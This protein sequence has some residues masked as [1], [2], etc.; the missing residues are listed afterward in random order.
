MRVLLVSTV[1]PPEIGGPS[2]HTRELAQ[3][4]VRRRHDAT[5][6]T[7]TTGSL[8]AAGVEVRTLPRPRRG[9]RSD[10]ARAFAEALRVIDQVR[11]DL[12]H[13]QTCDSP[14]ALL[15][16][17][18]ARWRRLPRLVKASGDLA[19]SRGDES[20][21]AGA[22]AWRTRGW[23]ELQSAIFA[24]YHLV[25]ATSPAVTAA[26]VER[27]HLPASR[28]HE[29]RNLVGVTPLA[30]PVVRSATGDVTALLLSRLVPA[31]GIDVAIESLRVPDAR[32]VRL[33]IIG[34]GDPDTRAA[35]IR[36][37]AERGVTERVTFED[38]VPPDAIAG[39]L[40]AAD[41][42]ALPSRQEN[43]GITL[44][45][46]MAAGLPIVASR[47]GGIPAVVA[48]EETAL[49]VPPGDPAALGAAL[50]RL[51]ADPGLRARLGAQGLIACRHFD[52][53]QHFDEVAAMYDRLKQRARG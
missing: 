44:V 11:P 16:G 12:V 24:Q 47:T 15:V 3:A 25:W 40:A 46:A 22:R 18:A 42:F 8:P 43:F 39:P 5:V 48:H 49:L 45:Q 2:L 38:A 31:K 53:E 4:L 7:Y 26:L 35:L 19:A 17:L 51:S 27:Y 13:V 52:L 34:S 36:L 37:A 32:R 20:P 33:R 10:H 9:R 30:R 41:I 28:L 6:L 21:R 23:R 50:G 14:L 1:Y 29:L